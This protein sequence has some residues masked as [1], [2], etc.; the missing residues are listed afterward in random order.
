MSD[1]SG[2]FSDD[3][4]QKL[5]DDLVTKGSKSLLDAIEVGM[6]IEDLDIYDL[7]REIAAT[8]N[9]DIVT[10]YSN[11]RDGS[12]NHMRAFY[13]QLEK[14]G[15]SYDAQYITDERMTE[16]LAGSNDMQGSGGQGGNGKGGDGVGGNSGYESSQNTVVAQAQNNEKGFF[17][18][19]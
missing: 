1:E 15:G 16:I 14:N 17:E 11:L 7:E 12:E 18:R 13:K 6:T 9:T 19:V 8:N 3:T 4:L 5:Y 2:V 10:V